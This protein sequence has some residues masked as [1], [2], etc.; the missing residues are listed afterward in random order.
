MVVPALRSTAGSMNRM[1]F[2]APVG[3]KLMSTCPASM[4]RIDH[5]LS[6]CLSDLHEAP[7]SNNALSPL[8]ISCPVYL[9][10][11]LVDVRLCS[12]PDHY[13]SSCSGCGWFFLFEPVIVV[14]D[15]VGGG[16]CHLMG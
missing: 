6:G 9:S 2:P 5:M 16:G 7:L 3:R 11:P 10:P 12:A 14:I 1:L 15:V 13:N 4:L 8:S